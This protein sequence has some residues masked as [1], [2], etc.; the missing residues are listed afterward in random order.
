MSTCQCG[1]G[2][3][4]PISRLTRSARGVKA[5]EHYKFCHGH[6][7]WLLSLEDR[8]WAKVKPAAADEC[9]LWQGSTTAQYGYGRMHVKGLPV[10]AHRIAY[11]L[12]IAE[13]PPGLHIDHL[14]LNPRCVNPWHMEPVTN[15]ENARRVHARGRGVMPQDR[16]PVRK[17]LTKEISKS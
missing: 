1:C 13:I 6:G 7:R 8:F 3:E 5:G 14:C 10:P 17:T 4:T 11:E 15:A 12:L 2:Q 16:R 9:W